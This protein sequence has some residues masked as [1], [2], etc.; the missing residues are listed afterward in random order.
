MKNVKV[1]RFP[2]TVQ[3]IVV[4]DNATVADCFAQANLTV[5]DNDNITVNGVQSS[6]S[7]SVN[8]NDRLIAAQGAKGNK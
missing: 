2:G 5:G 4:P 6:L 3:E 8:N 1:A 7:A